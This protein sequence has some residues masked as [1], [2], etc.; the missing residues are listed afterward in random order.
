[1]EWSLKGGT[2]VHVDVSTSLPV[3]LTLGGFVVV[4][5]LWCA[6]ARNP[7][8]LTWLLLANSICNLDQLDH[9]V[10]EGQ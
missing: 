7:R 9:I 4:T 8:M 6:V 1:M 3:M 10:L 5:A 2:T